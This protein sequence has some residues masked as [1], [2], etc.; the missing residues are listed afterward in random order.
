MKD[1]TLA[2]V[3]KYV[4]VRMESNGMNTSTTAEG[5]DKTTFCDQI[6]RFTSFMDFVERGNL[7]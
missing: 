4:V 3:N 1:A 2:W 5:W 7:F 6:P